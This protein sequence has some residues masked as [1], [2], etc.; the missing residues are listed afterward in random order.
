MD[1]LV[2][3]KLFSVFLEIRCLKYSKCICMLFYNVYY[4]FCN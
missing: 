3:Y 4:D 1:V 2:F